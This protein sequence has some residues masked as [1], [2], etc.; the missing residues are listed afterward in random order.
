MARRR[1]RS[2]IPGLGGP[3]DD[4]A[5]HGLVRARGLHLIDQA[6]LLVHERI[7]VLDLALL[8]LGVDVLDG[9]DVPDDDVVA[10]GPALRFLVRHDQSTPFRMWSSSF[11][12][13]RQTP[14]ASNSSKRASPCRRSIYGSKAAVYAAL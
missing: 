11:F 8:E 9:V 14:L 10:A 2:G 5:D 12:A 3:R 1:H 13:P 4:A 6:V 7:R